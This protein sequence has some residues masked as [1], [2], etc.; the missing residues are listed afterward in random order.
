MPFYFAR[1][2]GRNEGS[3]KA[4]ARAEVKYLTGLNNV[5]PFALLIMNPEKFRFVFEGGKKSGDI[6]HFDITDKRP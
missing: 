5:A 3:V 4:H 1:V 2:I 6:G